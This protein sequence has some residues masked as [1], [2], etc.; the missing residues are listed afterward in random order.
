MGPIP[1]AA[2]TKIDSTTSYKPRRPDVID[3]QFEGEAV[4]V[5]L[6]TGVYYAFNPVASAIWAGFAEGRSAST[7]A[8]SLGLDPATTLT[9]TQQLLEEAEGDAGQ[10]ASETEPPEDGPVLQRFTDMQDLLMLDPIHDIALDG[11]G[12]PVASAS[13]T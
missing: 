5:N 1:F 7:V 3:E 4:V 2:V 10:F 12:W 9:F 11:D 8:A 6:D 13:E